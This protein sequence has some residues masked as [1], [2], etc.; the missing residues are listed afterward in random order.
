MPRRN[1]KGTWGE[2]RV[3][4]VRLSVDDARC[5][6][7]LCELWQCNQSEALR[8]AL[9]DAASRHEPPQQRETS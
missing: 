3:V 1:L 8:R 7:A 9:V 4:T 5:L 6:S 2:S